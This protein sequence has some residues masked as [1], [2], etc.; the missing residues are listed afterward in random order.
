MEMLP[1]KTAINI[2]HFKENLQP[3]I[4]VIYFNAYFKKSVLQ[5]PTFAR[6]Q[7]ITGL[8]SSVGRQPL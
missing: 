2:G 6:N 1:I 4:V 8:L 5:L 7:P 3:H